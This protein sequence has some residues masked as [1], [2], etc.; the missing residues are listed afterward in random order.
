[1]NPKCKQQ[2]GKMCGPE[3]HQCECNFTK[4]YSLGYNDA[5]NR[6]LR[7]MR[8]SGNPNL[9]SWSLWIEGQKL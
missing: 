1:M 8:E 7:E 4:D 9:D 6:V 3:P 5:L 2:V